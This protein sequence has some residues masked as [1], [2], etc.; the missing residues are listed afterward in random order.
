[1]DDQFKIDERDL[2]EVDS[3]YVIGHQRPDTDAIA[4][5]LGYAWFLSVTGSGRTVAAR[6][7]QLPTQTTFA[8]SRFNCSA[9]PLL[10]GVSPLFAHITHPQNSLPRDA[11]LSEAMAQ[12]ASGPPLVPILDAE[13]KPLGV[14]TPMALAR[15][16]AALGHDAQGMAKALTMPCEG[17]VENVPTFSARQRILDHRRSL[18]RLGADDF[19]VTDE[20]GHYLGVTTRDD[21]LEP[22]RARLILVDHNELGQAV[23][24]ADEAEIVAVLDHHRLGNSPTALP[25][26]FMV[27]P[28]GST[29]TLVAERC[30]TEDLMLPSSLAGVLLS[31]ILSDTLV[32]RSPTTTPRDRTIAHWLAEL[33]GVDVESYGEELLHVTPG[34]M[35]RD[36]ADILDGDRK[37]YEMSGQAVSIGQVEVTNL[38]ELPQRRAELLDGMEERRE[39]ENLALICLMVTDIVTGTSHLLC[40]GATSLLGVLPFTRLGDGEWDLNRLVSRKK[41]LVPAISDVLESAF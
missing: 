30:R 39:K 26:P 7:G 22:P 15:A 20:E 28:V 40:R 29:C 1:M 36:I 3:T 18:L 35:S 6:A 9:P 2:W 33:A 11:P 34:L 21:V 14:I 37:S 5:A 24:G 16:Y 19:L 27:E 31:G 25:I 23:S 41:Q 8:L 38:Q 13:K 17:M 12:M 32:F 10:K 4:S